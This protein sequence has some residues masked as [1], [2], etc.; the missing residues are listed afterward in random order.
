MKISHNWLREYIDLDLPPQKLAEGLSMLGLEVESLESVGS[1]YDKFVVG[2]VL[3]KEKHP[4]ADKLSV[5]V[6]DIGKKQLQIV[7]GGPNVAAGQTVVVGLIGAV[8]PHNQHDLNAK[9]FILP[10]VQIRGVESSGMICSAYELGLGSDAEGI[11]VLDPKAKKGLPL[12]EYLGL[13][14]VIYET[15]ITANRG[16]WLSHIGV[17]REAQVLTKKKSKMPTLKLKE[18]K[19]RT[20]L[21]ARVTIKDSQACP[22]Y[23]A[24]VIRNVK[25]EPSPKWLQDRLESVGVRP[26]NNIVDITNYVLMETGHPLHAFDYDKVGGHHIIVRKAKKGERFV[27]LDEKERALDSETLLICDNEKPIAIAGVM[28]GMNSE[29]SDAT[30]NVLLESAYFDPKNIRKTS[31][32][33]G[34]STEA[35]QRFER[36]SD[37]EMV[38][39]A[40]NRSVQMMAEIAGGEVLKGVI[41]IY[42]TKVRKKT[43][44][45]RISR[46]NKILGTTLRISDVRKLLSNLNF[47]C[48][49]SDRD[50]LRITVPSYRNDV[51][52]EI[53][54]IEEVARTYGYD[55]IETKTKGSLV[56]SGVSG[57][58]EFIDEVRDYFVGAGFC[59]CMTNSF[60]SKKEDELCGGSGIEVL[61]PV[62]AELT[63][64]RTSLI[65]GMLNTIQNNIFKSQENLRLFEIGRV[66]HRISGKEGDPL[67][68]FAEHDKIII[69]MT[70]HFA[71]HQYGNSVRKVDRLDISGEVEAFLTK[72]FLDKYCFI[73]YDTH[74][75]LS[76]GDIDIEINGTYVGYLGQIRKDVLNFFDIDQD[77]YICEVDLGISRNFLPKERKFSSLPKF[78]VV[79]RDLA[80]VVD[81]D[82]TFGKLRDAILSVSS[83]LLKRVTLFDVFAGD[84]IGTGK[85]SLAIALEFRSDE[86]TLTDSEIQ[87]LMLKVIGA[88]KEKCGAT[89]R[90]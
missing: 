4:K 28:G 56:F 40:I 46:I 90:S 64:L 19:E 60:I 89:L 14:D 82:V 29:I 37:I 61:N 17:A 49:S 47:I 36:S 15:E 58:R 39:Y 23:A 68:S 18:G 71:P 77:V 79:E 41:D 6:V 30:T 59:E 13:T 48:A 55:K 1:K 57:K 11:L 74:R 45:L 16:D 67:S 63:R 31:K 33:L 10:K 22:R 9:P 34:L 44:I 25:I 72:F 12:A 43:L 27:T 52:S 81:G 85:K 65:P 76:V 53:D 62:S 5:C 3:K 20:S 7:C 32:L 24:R 26:I 35:S 8:V 42:P 87:Q 70:G 86:R 54:L 73:C 50:S 38:L 80:F 83:Q 78:P 51:V 75:P 69:V 21:A 88:A 66:Y 2:E 84:Q